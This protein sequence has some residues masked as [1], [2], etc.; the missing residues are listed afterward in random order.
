M[1]LFLI[2]SCSLVPVRPKA[3]EIAPGAEARFSEIEALNRGLTS[4]K[5]VGT[6]RLLRPAGPQTVRAAWIAKMPDSLRLELLGPA[7]TPLASLAAE[8]PRLDVYLH[9]RDKRYRGRSEDDGLKAAIGV[10]LKAEEI[11]A[12]LGG[13]IF[14]HDF[15]R[16]LLRGRLLVLEDDRGRVVQTVGPFDDEGGDRVVE[17]FDPEGNLRY[18]IRLESYRS[19]DGYSVPG[20]L[21][22]FARGQ[23][24][25]RLS[26]DRFWANPEVDRAAFE[27][28]LNGP[29]GG[30]GH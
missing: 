13:R 6:L 28:N 3:P 23:E 25:V 4:F 15:R 19:V 7:G 9:D 11:V 16:A 29:T 10:G 21:R 22:V 8:G 18:R 30:K 26:V 27:L 1:I 20:V 24:M 12:L 14:V 17:R 2:C 5:G